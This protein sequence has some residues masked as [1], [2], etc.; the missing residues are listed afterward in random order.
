MT[1]VLTAVVRA[2]LEA[3]LVLAAVAAVFWAAL[4]P[5]DWRTVVWLGVMCVVVAGAVLG[6]SALQPKGDGDHGR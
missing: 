4:G 5:Q 3:V 1:A 2:V 6:V